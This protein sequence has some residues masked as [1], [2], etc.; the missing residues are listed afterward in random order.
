LQPITRTIIQTGMRCAILFALLAAAGTTH[1][2]LRVVD[3]YGHTVTLAA[4]ARRVVSLA[5]H[6]T[7]LMYAAGAGERMA[8]ALAYSDYPSA[9]RALPRVGSE[10]AIDLEALVALR[11]DLVVAWPNAGSARAEPRVDYAEEAVNQT[12]ARYDFTANAL[13]LRTHARMMSALF[14]TTV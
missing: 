10:A 8:G 2:E 11:P 13:V 14:D 5:P 7:E 1:A 4:P 3:D 12:L 6:L 9:A